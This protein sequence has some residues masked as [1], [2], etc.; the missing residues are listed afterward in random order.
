MSF[1]W[2]RIISGAVANGYAGVVTLVIDVWEDD[3]AILLVGRE[4]RQDFIELE[5]SSL[6]CD[7][8]YACGNNQIVLSY[9]GSVPDS[10]RRD[11]G[12]ITG[13]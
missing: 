9:T 10:K 13:A 2:E 12:T 8:F 6:Y 11:L 5:S 4:V 7:P 1:W 3:P